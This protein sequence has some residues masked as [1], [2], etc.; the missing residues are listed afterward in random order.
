MFKF[1]YV[2]VNLNFEFRV[3]LPVFSHNGRATNTQHNPPDFHSNVFIKRVQQ[4]CIY[5][6]IYIQLFLFIYVYVHPF[7]VHGH[8]TYVFTQRKGYKHTQ[9][10]SLTFT[11]REAAAAREW[12]GEWRSFA[13]KLH[14]NLEGCQNEEEKIIS[15]LLYESPKPY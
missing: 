3:F 5:T 15:Y 12:R 6:L 10:L 7:Q 1:V 2:N 14:R 4:S 8:F 11:L 13:K 9:Q